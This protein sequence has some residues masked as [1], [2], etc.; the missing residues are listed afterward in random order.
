M[1]ARMAGGVAHEFNNVLAVILLQADMLIKTPGQD[2]AV[3]QRGLEIKRAAE[4]AAVLTRQLLAFAGKP[5]MHP[6]TLDLNQ[7]LAS[8]QPGLAGML[9]RKVELVT[10]FGSGVGQV[11][12][13]P[14]YLEQVFSILAA[15]A[16]DAMPAGGQ[17]TIATEACTVQRSA[18][19]P[20]QSGECA[21]G[22][23]V[24]ISVVDTGSGMD[25]ETLEHAFEP[26]FTTKRTGQGVGLGL[27]T[28]YGIVGKMGGRILV[29]S[30]PGCGARFQILLPRVSDE[31]AEPQTELR[32][33]H[34]LS[35]S[36]IILLVD[37]E[38]MVRRATS[39]ILEMF[40][41]QVIEAATG[42][43]ALEIC[44]ECDEPI[45]LLLTDIT[46]DQ[47]DGLTLAR[48]IG[49]QWPRIP[50]LFM[51]GNSGASMSGDG[52]LEA[53]AEFIEKP[54]EPEE[55]LRRIRRI[56]DRNRKRD[57]N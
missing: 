31:P 7:Q 21:A 28:V 4:R 18:E 23:Y 40:G 2:G 3:C 12:V 38:A 50:A 22:E 52:L 9:G 1:M 5:V 13:D 16:R 25:A 48:E 57:Q 10:Q 45:D 15:N 33:D 6:K 51:S 34:L 29:E 35:G 42:K 39:E 14:I 54:F 36:E 43:D 27:S 32:A 19:D 56:I 46:M 11:I 49:A 20:T 44:E 53:G 55:L 41:Y 37:D 8:F 47:M 30:E 24:K 17:V 26:F